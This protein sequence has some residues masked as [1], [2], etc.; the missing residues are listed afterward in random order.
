MRG[1]TGGNGKIYIAGKDYIYAIKDYGHQ[2]K[3]Y[4]NIK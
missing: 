1:I 4:G 3:R 2:L